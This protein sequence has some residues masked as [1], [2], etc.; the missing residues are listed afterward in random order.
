MAKPVT[1][2]VLLLPRLGEEAMELAELRRQNEGG[3]LGLR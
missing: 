1:A 2:A 3:R